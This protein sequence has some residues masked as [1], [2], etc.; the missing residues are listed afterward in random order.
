MAKIPD[1]PVR[2]ITTSSRSIT[3]AMP[4]GD[5]YE[6]ALERDLM[7]ILSF[8]H[9]VKNFVPQPL[10]VPYMDHEG[11][12]RL[13]TPDIFI[14]YRT[15]ILPAKNMRNILGEVKYKDEVC[16][17]FKEF[18]PKFKAAMRL[19]KENGWAFKIFTEDVIRIP[20]L[21]NANFLK[22]YRDDYPT[23]ELETKR[24]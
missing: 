23:P 4:D 15:D 1:Y 21:F 13:Y 6:S 11:K 10:K 17:H 2:K 18:K 14:E 7:I 19:A 8:D 12:N 5:R 24:M 9:N 16:K 22:R 3:G 20:Y